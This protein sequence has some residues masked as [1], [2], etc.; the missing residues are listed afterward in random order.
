MFKKGFYLE[1]KVSKT[2]L[3]N[4]YNVMLPLSILQWNMFN[5]YGSLQSVSKGRGGQNFKQKSCLKKEKVTGEIIRKKYFWGFV[6]MECQVFVNKGKTFKKLEG[7]DFSVL[8]SKPMY[9]CW[10]LSWLPCR[11][12]SGIKAPMSDL[13]APGCWRKRKPES[14]GVSVSCLRLRP[15]LFVWI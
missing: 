9:H 5:E 2:W 15:Q 12:Q 7:L 3:I 6:Q 14:N 8:Q 13:L 4:N 10:A 1:F 11:I